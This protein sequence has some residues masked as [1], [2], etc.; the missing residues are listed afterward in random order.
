M[1]SSAQAKDP[2][3]GAA[4]EDTAVVGKLRPHEARVLARR[5]SAPQPQRYQG[6]KKKR[7][8]SRRKK[9]AT[10]RAG[11]HARFRN[12]PLLASRQRRRRT[13]RRV[14]N[15]RALVAALRQGAPDNRRKYDTD[16]DST[17]VD[18]ESVSSLSYSVASADVPKS[19]KGVHRLRRDD[20]HDPKIGYAVELFHSQQNV[21]DETKQ[22]QRS[23]TAEVLPVRHE[24][25]I[26]ELKQIGT[27]CIHGVPAAT[28]VHDGFGSSSEGSDDEDKTKAVAAADGAPHN[29]PNETKEK[30]LLSAH[31]EGV[32][33]RHSM[34]RSQVHRHKTRWKKST[35]RAKAG[36]DKGSERGGRGGRKKK[37]SL[38]ASLAAG[39]R[40]A[41][42]RAWDV[43]LRDFVPTDIKFQ[44]RKLKLPTHGNY[45]A[46]RLRL[47]THLVQKGD[48]PGKQDH[49][50]SQQPM[51][52]K[53]PR[54]SD[55][56]KKVTLHRVCMSDALNHCRVD[57]MVRLLSSKCDPDVK[58]GHYGRPSFAPDAYETGSDTT[59]LH[60]AAAFGFLAGVNTLLEY[61]ATPDLRDNRGLTPIQ[62]ATMMKDHVAAT[63][64][65]TVAVPHDRRE[66]PMYT[67]QFDDVVASLTK[68]T[69]YREQ[70]KNSPLTNELS[71][72]AKAAHEARLAREEADRASRQQQVKREEEAVKRQ[73]SMGYNHRL[74]QELT[75][76]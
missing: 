74:L 4:V 75:R 41:K 13:G 62:L 56:R 51:P 18:T 54:P 66:K 50:P 5:Q 43:L 58:V 1:P 11:V 72:R 36:R 20:T 35:K 34:Q 76:Y 15:R 42:I 64:A 60:Q 48:L 53:P 6:T 23:K 30:Q 9:S 59:A 67:P 49:Q 44:L 47:A 45:R 52:K 65:A 69:Q 46:L 33:S 10:R 70:L 63:P 68:A 73:K 40:A 3:E 26:D 19:L 57:D 28:V 14:S 16:V 12:N 71:E 17:S 24:L 22:H 55:L 61:R 32:K 21:A 25:A 37:T 8:G 2:G 29:I 39:S 38:A 27:R 7:A 31:D